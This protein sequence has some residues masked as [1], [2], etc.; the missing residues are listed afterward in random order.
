MKS[1]TNTSG[2][3]KTNSFN[4][5]IFQMYYSFN[6]EEASKFIFPYASVFIN[7]LRLRTSKQFKCSQNWIGIPSKCSGSC[8]F[9]FAFTCSGTSQFF[10][11]MVIDYEFLV[12]CYCFL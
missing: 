10:P 9:S 2:L 1:L 6:I 3:V 11:N 7:K 4:G 12:I 5:R 8:Q